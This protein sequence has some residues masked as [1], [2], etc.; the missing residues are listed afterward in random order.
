MSD[1]WWKLLYQAHAALIL[2]GHEHV[3]AR[4]RPMDPNG[5]YDPKHGITQLTVGT[6]GEDLDT[7]ATT[8]T[9]YSNPNVVTAQDQAFGV[10]NLR[11]KPGGYSF[12][13]QPTAA[14][15]GADPSALNY[16]DSG[17]GSCH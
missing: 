9:G 12:S 17:S 11:L 8:P 1:A 7:L 14:G 15:P 13:Y 10:M 3:Y 16:S 6:G 5:K 4:F 2:N